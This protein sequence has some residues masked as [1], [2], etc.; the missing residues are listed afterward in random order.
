M[1]QNS[2]PQAFILPTSL[3]TFP[4]CEYV[5][6]LVAISIRYALARFMP[7]AV[8]IKFILSARGEP[9]EL[10]DKKALER[11]WN[12]S[13][14]KVDRLRKVGLLTWVDLSGGQGR[15]PM[16]RFRLEDVLAYE[17]RYL[18]NPGNQTC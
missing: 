18:Q 11:R 10:F 6:N 17:A 1:N 7:N 14:R 4:T 9:M 15:R 13:S 12:C 8:S 16:V 2:S 3:K 5:L